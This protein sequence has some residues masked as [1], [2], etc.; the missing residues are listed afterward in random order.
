MQS[1]FSCLSKF[2]VIQFS[3]VTRLKETL[4]GTNGYILIL[5]CLS[6]EARIST[7]NKVDSFAQRLIVLAHQVAHTSDAF[8][9]ESNIYSRSRNPNSLTPAA[10]FSFDNRIVFSGNKLSVIAE[11]KDAPRPPAWERA[12]N[13]SFG[14]AGSFPVGDDSRGQ[15]LPIRDRP[16]V[17]TT[18]ADHPMKGRISKL[19]A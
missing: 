4:C 7:R 11:L 16:S 9:P 18:V 19:R 5:H 6:I 14:K 15:L 3:R 10:R 17:I 1:Y 8:I 13:A 12:S 2:L